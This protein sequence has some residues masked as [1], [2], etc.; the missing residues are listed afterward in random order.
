MSDH[1][2]Y[3]AVGN[4]CAVVP[5]LLLLHIDWEEAMAIL[6]AKGFKALEVDIVALGR[7]LVG[8]AEYRRGSRLSDAPKAFDCSSFVKYLYGKLG[9]WLPRRS[10][11]QLYYQVSELH[12]GPGLRIDRPVG[13]F[14][15][16]LLPGD[17]VFTSGRID[18]YEE[19]QA[20]GVGHVCMATGEGTLLHAAS[21]QLGITEIAVSSLIESDLRAVHRPLKP[22]LV[23]LET[24]SN[25]EVET[26][27]DVR[28]IVLQSLPRSDSKVRE[29]LD[30]MA[31]ELDANSSTVIPPP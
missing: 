17:L 3:R 9:V 26:S 15:E 20:S 2:D 6:S 27:D 10:I 4:R 22:S 7:S 8:V 1:F 14:L 5:E 21:R 12:D 24:P 19:D 25:R 18:Y 31:A 13:K 11:Q 16:S 28:W 30:E 23:T 29:R